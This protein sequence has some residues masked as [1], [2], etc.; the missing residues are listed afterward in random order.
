MTDVA[1][2]PATETSSQQ[3]RTNKFA[4]V[5]IWLAA[6]W[7]PIDWKY[8]PN[9]GQFGFVAT[10]FCA[11]IGMFYGATALNRIRDGRESGRTLA[12]WTLTLGALGASFAFFLLIPR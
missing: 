6:A 10:F 1:A 9:L 4:K 2:T 3:L 5:G 7:L 8:G 12:R 11:P